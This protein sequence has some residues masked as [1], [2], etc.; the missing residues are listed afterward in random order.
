MASM[1]GGAL[2]VLLCRAY[3]SHPALVLPS[4]K[5]GSDADVVLAVQ[6]VARTFPAC[7]AQSWS[8]KPIRPWGCF[9]SF[10]E[11]CLQMSTRHWIALT[12]GSF[13]F[14]KTIS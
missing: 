7:S 5:E 1:A 13:V 11:V 6:V 10:L 3:V 9:Q 8:Q 2:T 4:R 14:F 12:N